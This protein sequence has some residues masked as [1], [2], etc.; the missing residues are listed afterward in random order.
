MIFNQ[1]CYCARL[2]KME[3]PE[4]FSKQAPINKTEI[5]SSIQSL[6]GDISILNTF[7]KEAKEVVLTELFEIITGYGYSDS[8][9]P[10]ELSNL[11][12]T[13]NLLCRNE[14][15]SNVLNA[16]KHNIPI[17]IENGS[18]Q[19]NVCYMNPDGFRVAM[20]E[21]FGGKEVGENIKTVITFEP[22]GLRELKTA[23]Q[24]DE[25]W[26]MKPDTASVSLSG[27]GEIRGIDISMITLRIPKTSVP[28]NLLTSDE[29]MN[30]EQKFIFR[31][32]IKNNR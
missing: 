27:N 10:E 19:L 5:N 2:I 23:S 1:N 17:R 15:L 25:I 28:D 16:I 32:F 14:K 7:S 30:E 29:I 3:L 21:G 8:Y 4:K 6:I 22:S 20:L 13:H 12:Y 24:D 18:N 9:E 11:F 26:G 31:R